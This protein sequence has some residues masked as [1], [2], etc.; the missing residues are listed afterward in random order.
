MGFIPG[1]KISIK[2]GVV[3]T[4]TRNGTP[5]EIGII[6]DL[7]CMYGSALAGAGDLWYKVT[8]VGYVI[9][10]GSTRTLEFIVTIPLTW[11]GERAGQDIG[12]AV[13]VWNPDSTKGKQ[14]WSR[15]YDDAFDVSKAPVTTS[16]IE[17]S[18]PTVG[19]A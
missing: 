3:N 13:W 6:C 11:S 2:F 10:A 8:N 16:T 14:L 9:A 12:F 17:V 15:Q 19:L 1:N 4:S 5:T 18:G 7:S